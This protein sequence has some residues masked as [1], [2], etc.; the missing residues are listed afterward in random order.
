MTFVD[1]IKVC[2]SKYADFSGR[3]GRS[4]FWWWV[5]FNFLAYIALAVVSD[6]LALVFMVATLVPYFAV[7]ARRLHD[8]DRSGWLQLVGL[9]PLVGWVFVIVWCAQ[10]SKS[11]NKY[12]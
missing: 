12:A 9:I 5:L 2:F 6:K 4:E 1:A 3:A 10:D 8:T 11:P 7:T